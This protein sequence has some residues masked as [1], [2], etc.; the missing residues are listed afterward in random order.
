[1]DCFE[2]VMKDGLFKYFVI[3]LI[4]LRASSNTES[5]PNIFYL[6]LNISS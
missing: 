4:C 5:V 1:M 3:Q 6:N 2:F